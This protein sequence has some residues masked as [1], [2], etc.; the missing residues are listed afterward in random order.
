MSFTGYECPADAGLAD[1]EYTI[2]KLRGDLDSFR[3]LL[4]SFVQRITEQAR[5]DTDRSVMRCFT[6]RHSNLA[7]SAAAEWASRAKDHKTGAEWASIPPLVP[8]TGAPLCPVC[9]ICLP[10]LVCTTTAFQCP[11][12]KTPIQPL[13]NARTF[14]YV[15]DVLL[16]LMH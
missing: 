6:S 3:T 4:L 1:R 13:G 14:L 16:P 5:R 10:R 8:S 12:L 15:V 7:S 2:G 11:M 9:Y